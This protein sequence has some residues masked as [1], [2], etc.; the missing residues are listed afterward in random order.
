MGCTLAI[1]VVVFDGDF[2]EWAR[3]RMEWTIASGGPA[4]GRQFA[5]RERTNSVRS[6][7][8]EMDP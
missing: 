7:L 1:D 2:V 5:M 6:I 3:G 4:D 8:H